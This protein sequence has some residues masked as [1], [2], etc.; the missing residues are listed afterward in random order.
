MALNP[1]VPTDCLHGPRGRLRIE[2]P[3]SKKVGPTHDGIERRAELVRE[4]GE[5]LVFETIGSL[6]LYTRCLLAG[7]RGTGR[8][9]LLMLGD[10]LARPDHPH[11]LAAR[12]R[13]GYSLFEKNTDAPVGP[14]DPVLEAEG[15]LLA[16][17]GGHHG[18]GMLAIVGMDPFQECFVAAPERGGVEPVDRVELVRP[19][20]DV[21]FD[22]PF[23]ASHPRR[24]LSF[25]KPG[26][27]LLQLLLG[28]CPFGDLVP[29]LLIGYPELL[30]TFRDPLL[31]LLVEPPHGPLDA[32]SARDRRRHGENHDRYHRHE[33]LEQ[34]ERYVRWAAG[35][36]PITS[37]RPDDGHC[38][39]HHDG[40]RGLPLTEAER[41]PYQWRETE[42]FQRV[43]PVREGGDAMEHQHGHRGQREQEQG[44]LGDL[45]PCP[46]Y[47]RLEPPEQGDGCHDESARGVSEPPGQPDG[48]EIA[49]CREP[50]Q[51]K[52]CDADRGA[53]RGTQHPCKDRELEDIVRLLENTGATGESADEVAPEQSFQC[54]PCRDAQR[55]SRI[56]R[57]RNVDEERPEQH[58]RPDAITE[59]KER[60]ERDSSRGP[61][62]RSARVHEREAQP[63]LSREQIDRGDP[64]AGYE[65][66]EEPA[67]RHRVQNSPGR[68][69]GLNR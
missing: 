19:P 21:S 51:G 22:V 52:R 33:A 13:Q 15:L 49:P 56:S 10:V 29:K 69:R 26:L 9:R 61:N 34:E 25:A 23:P 48:P 60:R 39:E 55:G 62:R 40:G 59:N 8:L 45:L 63:Y 18:V 30:G 41:G 11:R 20:E 46:E 64:E 38:G 42:V 17:G 5:K 66:R 67:G 37:Q 68:D 3:F 28:P 43:S 58:G 50:T 14:D 24:S 32:A 53:H 31:Q 2:P 27:A 54:V 16:N 36:G 35:K 4:R 44:R 65:A 7:Q 1:D 57:R 12:V 6:R 47:L